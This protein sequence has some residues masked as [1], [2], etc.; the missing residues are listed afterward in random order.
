MLVS[1]I[2]AIVHPPKPPPV[3]IKERRIAS[4]SQPP[5][6]HGSLHKDGD[7]LHAGERQLADSRKRRDSTEQG[8]RDLPQ[9]DS[10]STD[11]VQQSDV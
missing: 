8:P 4:G 9:R 1:S 6:I 11:V 5:G 7:S 2:K 10:D 3:T